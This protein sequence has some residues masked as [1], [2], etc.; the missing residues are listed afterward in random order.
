MLNILTQTKSKQWQF[1]NI[2]NES[3]CFTDSTLDV[4]KNKETNHIIYND[5]RLLLKIK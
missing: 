4:G 1:Q 5:Y 2:Q 3:H